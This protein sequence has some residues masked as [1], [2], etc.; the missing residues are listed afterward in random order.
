MTVK[1]TERSDAL[2]VRM[3]AGQEIRT[4]TDGKPT[5]VVGATNGAPVILDTDQWD[6]LR[7]NKL[8]RLTFRDKVRGG[9]RTYSTPL[10]TFFAGIQRDPNKQILYRNGKSSDDGQW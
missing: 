4:E 2:P 3:G 5:G 8:T 10:A 1:T 6:I 9:Y 7:H